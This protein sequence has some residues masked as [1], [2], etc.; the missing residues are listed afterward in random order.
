MSPERSGRWSYV[1]D[2]G[3]RELACATDV[4]LGRN[5]EVIASF[6][7]LER[8]APSAAE[9]PALRSCIALALEGAGQTEQASALYLRVVD[10]LAGEP[11]AAVSLAI[12]RTQA[13]LGRRA[14]AQQWLDRARRD[15]PRIP[16]FDFQLRQVEKLLR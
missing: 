8:S 13:K 14:E 7:E 10:S 3:V 1:N 15:G 16:S 11:P 9:D 12:A 2:V 4:A 6:R 5:A